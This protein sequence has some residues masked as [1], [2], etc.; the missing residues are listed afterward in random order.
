MSTGART[1]ALKVYL[2]RTAA[3]QIKMSTESTYSTENLLHS[4]LV[5]IIANSITALRL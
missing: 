1:P 5:H 4:V 2:K 3:R